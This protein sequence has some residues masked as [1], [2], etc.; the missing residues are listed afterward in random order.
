M[1]S[2]F[3]GSITKLEM[4]PSSG[5]VFEVIINGEKI[6]SKQETGVFPKNPDIIA[7][8]EALNN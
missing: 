4:I 2:H 3:R 5:G 1:F 7:K 6:Y 8:M